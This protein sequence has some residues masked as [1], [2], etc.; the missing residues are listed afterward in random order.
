MFQGRFLTTTDLPE[1]GKVMICKV[2]LLARP[3]NSVSIDLKLT[4]IRIQLLC[5]DTLNVYQFSLRSIYF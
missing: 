4:L 3:G 1:V 5:L 2:I